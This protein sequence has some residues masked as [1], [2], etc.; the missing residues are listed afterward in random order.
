MPVTFQIDG[1]ERMDVGVV[2]LGT[3]GAGVAQN[4]AEVGHRVVLVDKGA[5]IAE[6]AHNLIVSNCRMNRMFNR[7][8]VDVDAVAG[9]MQVGAG[10][11]DLAE[12]DFVI[13]N[14]DEDV[15]GKRTVYEAL[16]IV[17]KPETIFIANTSA[18]PITRIGGFCGRADRVVGVHFMN[19]VPVKGAV[20]FIPGHHT[21]TAT[22]KATLELLDSMGKRAIEVKDSPGFVSNRVLMLTCNEAAFL[23]HE[24]VS[25]AV[26]VDD[27]FRSCFGHP[28]GPLETADLIGIDTVLR[29]L[30]VLYAEFGDPKFRPCPLLQHM[31]DAGLLGRKSGEGFY[32][33]R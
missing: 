28:M 5:E 19:P 14:I 12:A 23:V 1:G 10:Y 26:Q 29:S 6:R 31:V 30:Q 15:A 24:S 4:L 18:I 33:Y 20:E 32:S 25:Q 3:I 11:E 9:R 8:S 17:C 13:E 2:G 22:L 21:S 16:D 7:P 27:V